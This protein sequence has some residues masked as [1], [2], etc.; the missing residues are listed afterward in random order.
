M[1]VQPPGSHKIGCSGAEEFVGILRQSI[2]F[3]R[4]ADR[5][6]GWNTYLNVSDRSMKLSKIR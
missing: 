6:L 2:G 1:I 3:A 4:F 5:V